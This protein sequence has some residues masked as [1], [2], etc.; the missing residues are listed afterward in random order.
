MRSG[1]QSAAA[2]QEKAE[3]A[4]LPSGKAMVKAIP[5]GDSV[6]L[7][8]VSKKLLNDSWD[9][10][11]F[12]AY[13]NVPRVGTQTRSEEPFAFEAREVVREL[14]IGKKIDFNTEYMAGSKKAI[15][16]T[17]DNED[18]ATLLVS[19]SLAK[20]GERRGNTVEGGLHDKL[21]AKQ[22]EVKD[23]QKGVWS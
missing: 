17:V 13:V 14:L 4:P 2:A 21:L 15:S 19:R 23:K 18:L 22:D 20:V 16:I 12:L 5:S 11:C 8:P 7:I 6:H 3:R 9:P 10:H 1:K